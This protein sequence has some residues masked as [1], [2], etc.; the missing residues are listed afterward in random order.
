MAVS[1]MPAEFSERRRTGGGAMRGALL[2]LASASPAV[3]AL[4]LVGV[5]QATA[6]MQDIAGWAVLPLIALATA[7]AGAWIGARG[8]ARS[9][10]DR[11]GQLIEVLRALASGD[12]CGRLGG[13]YPK[14]QAGDLARAVD[15]VVD[16]VLE[17]RDSIDRHH[18]VAELS[19]D[20]ALRLSTDA[21]LLDVSRSVTRSLG[22]E[23]QEMIGRSCY[24]FL[25]PDDLAA[26][27]RDHDA[28]LSGGTPTSTLRLRRKAGGYMNVELTARLRRDPAA[29]RAVEIVGL[30]RDATAKAEHARE[31]ERAKREAISTGRSRSSFLAHMSHDLRTPLNIIIGLSQI[32]RD[33]MF[34]PVGAQRYVDYARDIESSGHDLLDLINDLLDLSKVESGRWQLEE[35]AVSVSRNV[36]SVFTMVSDRARLAQVT[37]E[38]RLSSGLPLLLADERAVRQMLLNVVS[39]TLKR[40]TPASV[41]SVDGRLEKGEIVLDIRGS[42]RAMESYDRTAKDTPDSSVSLALASDLVK[43]HGG[44]F[45]LTAGNGDQLN[46]RIAFPAARSLTAPIASA[47]PALAS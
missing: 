25:H 32:I 29:D 28:L 17:L 22:Y 21:T 26:A 27:R 11:L 18:V 43:L 33:Q 40:V 5:G 45:S 35:R 23:R 46:I 30:A 47:Q 36:E 8:A 20:I 10:D 24:D 39:N 1:A 38:S 19:T 42:A 9:A 44:R 37:M 2:G 41:L 15:S 34:G 13:P 7:G 31:I 4:T 12:R 14:G 16:R 6:D 3:L